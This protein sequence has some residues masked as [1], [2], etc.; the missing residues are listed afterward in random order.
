M[1]YRKA[2]VEIGLEGVVEEIGCE[3][4]RNLATMSTI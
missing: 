4:Q 3:A 2:G 1:E